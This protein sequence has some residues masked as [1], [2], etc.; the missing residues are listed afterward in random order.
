MIRQGSSKWSLGAKR[1]A[2][3]MDNGAKDLFSAD[4]W[5]RAWP[6]LLTILLPLA[7]ALVY[8]LSVD[9]LVGKPSWDELLKVT[10][11]KEPIDFFAR[12]VAGRIQF[13]IASTLL[14]IAACAAV[15]LATIVLARRVGTRAAIGIVGALVIGLIV[16][17]AIERRGHYLDYGKIRIVIE[18]ISRALTQS[19]EVL[20][21][22][23]RAILDNLLASFVG[24]ACML[25]CFAAVA[26][27]AERGDTAAASLQARMRDLER[28]TI[29]SA[30]FLVLLTALNKS[31]VDW[32]QAFL[33][34]S[35]QKA[36]AYLAGAIGTF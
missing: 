8:A 33:G 2:Q 31:L 16:I 34:G 19:G 35:E 13:G 28:T 5:W 1:D 30:V 6:A 27:R 29:F 20:A 12:D 3:Q 7:I 26:L 23:D 14:R 9:H 4:A 17:Y 10:P 11:N 25:A 32:P 36:Y 22:I 24:G 15:I 21:N 18:K